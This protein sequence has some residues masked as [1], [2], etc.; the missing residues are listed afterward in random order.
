MKRVTGFLMSIIL[1]SAGGAGLVAQDASPTDSGK[2]TP[3]SNPFA[4]SG[5]A[6]KTEPQ[7][8]LSLLDEYFKGNE[9]AR[10][11]NGVILTVVGAGVFVLGGTAAGFSF[12]LPGSSFS[13]P[14]EQMAARGFSVG[15]AG[16][17]LL[18]GGIGLFEL[19]KP[20]DKYLAEYAYLYGEDDPVVQEALAYGIMKDIAMEAKRS[21]ITRGIIGVASPLAIIGGQAM[22]ASAYDDWDSFRDIAISAAGSSLPSFISGLVMLIGALPRKSACSETYRATSGAYSVNK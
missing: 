22:L 14:E 5:S 11:K 4:V 6:A 15:T 18:F 13:S 7:F 17:G 1:I 19:S 20:K 10:K 16:L 9:I 21:R 12:L 2:A 8:A 3:L